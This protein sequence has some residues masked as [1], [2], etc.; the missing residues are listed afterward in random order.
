MKNSSKDLMSE[1]TKTHIRVNVNAAIIRDEQ[2]LLI[3]FNDENGIHY[4][5]PGGGL[6]AGESLSEGLQRECREEACVEI[7][8]EKLL[9]VWEYV[10]EKE[11][12]MV[13]D[14]V[15]PLLAIP[16]LFPSIAALIVVFG[17]NPCFSFSS[18]SSS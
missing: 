11:N 16:L 14:V 1:T 4:N 12:F 7:Q 3:E 8:I 9:M 15:L 17:F 2:I 6:D 18:S 5:L 10:P 13:L